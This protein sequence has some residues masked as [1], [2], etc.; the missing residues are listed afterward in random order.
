MMRRYEKWC[1]AVSMGAMVATVQNVSAMEMREDE[2]S[3]K[4]EEKRVSREFPSP[5]TLFENY[6]VCQSLYDGKYGE[7]GG[8]VFGQFDEISL[9]KVLAILD[10]WNNLSHKERDKVIAE[11]LPYVWYEGRE[12]P[13]FFDGKSVSGPTQE[14]VDEYLKAEAEARG[15]G[16]S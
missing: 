1:V 3:V 10:E 5:Y 15:K 13:A 2:V 11:I 7:R 6:A 14:F 9:E 16:K 8:N 12:P 4:V